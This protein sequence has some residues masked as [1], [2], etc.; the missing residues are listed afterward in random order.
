MLSNWALCLNLYCSK[1]FYFDTK[2]DI[3][4]HYSDMLRVFICGAHS[5]GK[6]TLLKRFRKLSEPDQNLSAVNEVA[7]KIIEKHGWQKKD[8]DPKIHPDTFYEL[9]LKILQE[10][11]RKDEELCDKNTSYIS[12]R[13]LDPIIYCKMYLDEDW[14]QMIMNSIEAKECIK[15]HK[16]INTTTVVL[17]PHEE[18]LQ[19]D[20]VRLQPK[21]DELKKF[22]D[23]LLN[24]LEEHDI[25]FETIAVLD[26][27]K[28][29]SLLKSFIKAKR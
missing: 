13:G 16:A 14:F 7:R 28:R 20:G 24:F 3:Y 2:K 15:R 29:V 4:T 6:T 26:L 22:T 5:T 1:T 27:D 23:L 9:Q 11:L 21:M 25:K 19:E 18:C 12:D 17:L 8:F 10:Q